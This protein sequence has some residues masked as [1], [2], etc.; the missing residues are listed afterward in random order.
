MIKIAAQFLTLLEIVCD[1]WKKTLMQHRF[2]FWSVG[3]A[4]PK[5]RRFKV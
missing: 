3:Y 5:K 1:S 4:A 2:A